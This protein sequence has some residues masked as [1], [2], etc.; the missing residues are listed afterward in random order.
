MGYKTWQ[1]EQP[2]TSTSLY[3]WYSSGKLILASTEQYLTIDSDSSDA[4]PTMEGKYT[5]S[6][7]TPLSIEYPP[8]LRLQ[9]RGNPN[10]SYYLVEHYSTS[11]SWGYYASIY[12]TMQGYYWCETTKIPDGSTEQFRIKTVDIMGNESTDMPYTMVMHTLPTPPTV[13]FTYTSSDGLL[14][15]SS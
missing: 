9:W 3:E 5:N 6:T 11:S 4:P 13:N 10:C 12:E 7:D 1:F 15:V 2:L 8:Y 14:T